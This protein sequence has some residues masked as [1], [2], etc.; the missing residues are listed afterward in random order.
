MRFNTKK[1]L[2]GY[3]GKNENDRKLVDRMISR[4][5]VYKHWDVYVVIEGKVDRVSVIEENEKL[6]KEIKNLTNKIDE[7]EYQ[8]DGVNRSMGENYN[9]IIHR[10][11]VYLK[12]VLHINVRY[13]DLVDF[14]ENYQKIRYFRRKNYGI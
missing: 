6:K 5:E 10:I 4:G 9:E 8:L 12:E 11:Y 7:L 2:L 1:E 3:L 13:D 14:I